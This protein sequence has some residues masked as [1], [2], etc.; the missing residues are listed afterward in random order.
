MQQKLPGGG[1]S[2]SI[3]S[4]C[5]L[6]IPFSPLMLTCP[7]PHCLHGRS[8]IFPA[9]PDNLGWK[10]GV[11]WVTKNCFLWQEAKHSWCAS[12]LL[13][14]GSGNTSGPMQRWQWRLGSSSC[15]LLLVYVLHM[16]EL[17]NLSGPWCQWLIQM[18]ETWRLPEDCSPAFGCERS[19]DFYNPGFSCLL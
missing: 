14:R 13:F 9:Q 15:I 11:F 18:S 10:A 7:H 2:I 12:V 5:F 1:D 6:P 4:S 16:L 17:W 8:T 19:E 3:S